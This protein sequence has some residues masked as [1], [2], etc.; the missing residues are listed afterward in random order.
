[1]LNPMLTPEIY[2]HLIMY[3]NSEIMLP[4]FQMTAHL[5][6]LLKIFIQWVLQME[7]TDETEDHNLLMNLG[8]W[9]D[10]TPLLPMVRTVVMLNLMQ[11]RL[12]AVSNTDAMISRLQRPM[13][14]VEM[15]VSWEEGKGRKNP[16]EAEAVFWPHRKMWT[17]PKTGQEVN[18]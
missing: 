10:P 16:R 12:Q 8:P 18:P 15:N 6:P 14:Q 3:A 13:K 1:M 17:C 11:L 2:K 7:V 5:P 4:Q 9:L